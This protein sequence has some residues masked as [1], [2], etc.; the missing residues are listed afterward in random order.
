M[1]EGDA[2]HPGDTGRTGVAAPV[3]AA[4]AGSP[5]VLSLGASGSPLLVVDGATGDAPHV[6]RIASA[7][8]PFPPARGNQ[9]PG[10]RRFIGPGDAAAA[11]YARALLRALAPAINAAF[12]V[13]GFDLLDASF[14]LV[15][16]RPEALA[17][18][19]RAPHFD[20]VD[21]LHL[22]VLHYLSGTDGGGTAFFRQRATGIERVTAANNRAFVAAARAEAAGWRGYIAGSNAS[23]ERIG[24]VAAEPDRVIVYPGGLLHSGTIPPDTAF[25]AAPADGR[26]TANFFVR[27]RPRAR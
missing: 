8:A 5:R 14:S 6:V 21:P 26:L 12:G 17:P 11:G 25:S 19:Q 3:R 23:F 18:V 20:S 1:R 22:A 24:A 13:D 27:G 2:G 10:L 7:L 4:A 15:T 16:V 9:Y